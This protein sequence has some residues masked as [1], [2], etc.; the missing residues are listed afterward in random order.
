MLREK[1]HMEDAAKIEQQGREFHLSYKRRS[2]Q[3]AANMK[4]TTLGDFLEGLFP[5]TYKRQMPDG[6]IVTMDADTNEPIRE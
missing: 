3:M 4:G 5:L 6:S 1:G 2:R